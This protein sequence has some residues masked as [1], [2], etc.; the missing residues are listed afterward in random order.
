M[1]SKQG[2]ARRCASLVLP[3]HFQSAPCHRTALVFRLRCHHRPVF[4]GGWQL[5]SLLRLSWLSRWWYYS[6]TSRDP[7]LE[8]SLSIRISAPSSSSCSSCARTAIRMRG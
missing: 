4:V 6:P 2:L 8:R 1:P 3:F 5:V 7:P